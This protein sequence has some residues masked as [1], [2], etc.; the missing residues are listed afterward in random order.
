MYRKQ[1][2]ILLDPIINLN[3]NDLGPWDNRE[4]E[5]ANDEIKTYEI[6]TPIA[7]IQK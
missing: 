5:F 1:N 4:W 3:K 6:M 2:I 7:Q